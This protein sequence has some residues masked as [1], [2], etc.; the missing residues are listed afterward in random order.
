[1]SLE[2]LVVESAAI[3]GLFTAGEVFFNAALAWEYKISDKTVP[4]PRKLDPGSPIHGHSYPIMFA[5]GVPATL[6]LHHALPYVEQF[7]GEYASYGA[8]GLGVVALE[9]ICG[10]IGMAPWREVYG[11]LEKRFH[12]AMPWTKRLPLSIGDKSSFLPLLPVWSAV[13]AALSYAHTVLHNL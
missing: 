6:A 5:M 10:K 12:K 9:Y 3:G 2:G 1:M 7:A 13:G 8:F 11:Y 4:F